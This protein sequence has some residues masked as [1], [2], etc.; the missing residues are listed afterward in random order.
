MILGD[1]TTRH[2]ILDVD[3]A[4]TRIAFAPRPDI[5]VVEEFAAASASARCRDGADA[6][7]T[8]DQAGE[9]AEAR[10]DEM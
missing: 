8:I 4:K 3:I 10:A 6:R 2:A 1:G 7:A 9:D 5:H